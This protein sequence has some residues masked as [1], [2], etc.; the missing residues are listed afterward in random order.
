MLSSV[1]LFTACIKDDFLSDFV[2]PEIRILSSVE[3]LALG[4]EFQFES[5]Y[6]NNVGQEENAEAVWTSS[7]PQIISI[8]AGGRAIAE[9]QGEA[10]ITVSVTQGETEVSNSL[11]VVVGTETVSNQ[12][13]ISGEIVT[14]TFYTLEG[15]FVLSADGEDLQLEIGSDYEASSGLPGLYIYLSNNRNSIGNALEIA[16]VE[17]FQ[18]AHSYTIENTGLNDFSY[19]VYYCK[20]FNVKVGEAKLN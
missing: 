6:F 1:L 3:S 17:T 10:N 4:D 13:S 5:A 2:D 20:P 16:E 9:S 12:Q 15:G 7:D 19:I 14:T 18:G 11:S 8:T